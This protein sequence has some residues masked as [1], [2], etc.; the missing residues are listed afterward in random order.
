MILRPA[1]PE[2]APAMAALLNR[3]IAIGGTTAHEAPFTPEAIITHYIAG[4][5]PICCH[6]AE[7][8]QG[9]IGFQSVGHNAALPEGWGDIGTFVASDRQRTGAGR[10][11]FAVTMT[12]ARGAGVTVLNATIRADNAPG[13]GYY[14]RRGFVDYAEDP[15]FRLKSGAR[16]GRVSRRFDL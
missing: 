13:L 15:D 16:V 9:L 6:L 11:L 3:I 2:D 10:A 5:E 1:R 8:E 14:A 7:D 4:D 12:A